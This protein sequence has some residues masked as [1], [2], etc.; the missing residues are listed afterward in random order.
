MS[1]SSSSSGGVQAA[2]HPE[3]SPPSRTEGGRRRR[4]ILQEHTTQP[5][6]RIDPG[7]E[8]LHRA[9]ERPSRS[10]EGTRR[11]TPPSR[12]AGFGAKV[13]QSATEGATTNPY[14]ITLDRVWTDW[15]AQHGVSETIAAALYLVS[16][17]RKA[18]EVVIKLTSG[19]MERVIAFVQHWPDRFP[20]G[21]LAALKNSRPTPAEASAP[22]DATERPAAPYTQKSGTHPG[23][24]AETVRRRMV[25]EDL[26]GAGLS[27]RTISAGTGIPRSSVHRAMR[28]IARAEAKKEVAIAEIAKAL[29]GK[30]VRSGVKGI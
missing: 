1:R 20:P 3:R 27:V 4:K 28:A 18:D 16:R 24:L 12:F 11:W 21:A 29:L 5:G 25:V 13:L 26:R 23:T 9:D 30:K 6:E 14:G 22:S 2:I 17:N 8:R 10:T 7:P 19:E 15:A